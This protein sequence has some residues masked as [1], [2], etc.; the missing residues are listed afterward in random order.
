[1]QC[2]VERVVDSD[3]A[4]SG[5]GQSH[6]E[7]SEPDGAIEDP[8]APRKTPGLTHDH[9]QTM[10]VPRPEH[11]GL[12]APRVSFCH[13]GWDPPEAGGS[14]NS[15]YQLLGETVAAALSREPHALL[16]RTQYGVEPVTGGVVNVALVAPA[17]GNRVLPLG[18]R[19]H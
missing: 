17:I 2:R 11:L 7:L 9:P 19:Y 16:T 10:L 6:R 13:P 14:R 4:V 15:G 5:G 3:G 8:R 18:P 12:S 1:M